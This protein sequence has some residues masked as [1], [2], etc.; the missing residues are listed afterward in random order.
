MY[1]K[2]KIVSRPWK[3]SDLIDDIQGLI[4]EEPD[5]YLNTKRSTLCMARDFLK[6]YFSG[7]TGIYA[8]TR[9]RKIPKTCKECTLSAIEFY[10]HDSERVCTITG[11]SCPIEK[12][13][14]GNW[15]YTKPDWCPLVE[16]R[17]C[18]DFD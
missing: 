7:K 18:T 16:C 15:G 6:L 9:L 3:P 12:K 11:K 10:H 2:F 5:I 4:D 13:A 8:K 1:D 17:G 14:S